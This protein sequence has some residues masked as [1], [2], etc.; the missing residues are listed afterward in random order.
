MYLETRTLTLKGANGADSV[1]IS[2]FHGFICGPVIMTL[3]K[4]RLKKGGRHSP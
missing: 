1:S 3:L 4:D 2:H